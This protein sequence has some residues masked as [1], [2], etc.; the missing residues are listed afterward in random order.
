MAIDDFTWGPI[1]IGARVRLRFDVYRLKAGTEGVVIAQHPPKGTRGDAVT[2]RLHDGTFDGPRA[3]M[4]W[5]IVAE[6]GADER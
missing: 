4:P 3:C 2:V 5:E 6:G 1:P